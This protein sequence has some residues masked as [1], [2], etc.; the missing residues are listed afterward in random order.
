MSNGGVPAP[1]DAVAVADGY[2]AAAARRGRGGFPD[3][4]N[5]RFRTALYYV[6]WGGAGIIMST[7]VPSLSVNP[8][9]LMLNIVFVT[10]GVNLLLLSMAADDMPWMEPAAARLE[11]I[12]ARMIQIDF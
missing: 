5:R 2:R 7:N 10:A 4:R 6:F 8:G 11:G 9:H 3:L 12:L 1:L